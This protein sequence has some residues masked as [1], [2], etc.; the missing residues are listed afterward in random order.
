MLV[1]GN[2]QQV[3]DPDDQPQQNQRLC[4]QSGGCISHWA[5]A[6]QT[7]NHRLFAYVLG[8]WVRR[9]GLAEPAP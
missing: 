7:G 8:I 5:D 3:R 6:S 2:S 1:P 4:V 9:L